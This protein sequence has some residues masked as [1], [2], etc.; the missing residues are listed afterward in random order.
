MFKPK[1][2]QH[3]QGFML[4]EVLV[5][6]LITSVFVT[7]AMQGMVLATIFKVRAQQYTEATAWIQA[8]LENVKYQASQYNDNTKCAANSSD[9]GYAD[10]LRD[11]I[12]GS[13]QT[14]T[15]V[16]EFS[17]SS[18]TSKPFIMRRTTTPSSTGPY[19]VLQ[20]SYDV[21]PTSGGSSLTSGA[22]SGASSIN[23]A[24]AN[25]FA[26]NENLRI[27]SAPG[28][29]KI[30]AINGN[31]LSLTPNLVTA[32]P[33]GAAVVKTVANLYTEVIPNAALQCP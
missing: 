20:I 12:T 32:Q 19:N 15:N 28:N 5:A 27:G 16:S 6:I 24:S 17:R 29:Y 25:Y 33:L 26:V 22:A 9:N 4:V 10:G 31:A 14:D 11:A 7:V 30:T 8:D 1:L 2:L 18:R 3:E 13:P 21:S 23:V